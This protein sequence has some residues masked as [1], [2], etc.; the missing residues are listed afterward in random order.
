LCE[1]VRVAQA[2]RKTLTRTSALPKS[3]TDTAFELAGLLDDP[4]EA[5]AVVRQAEDAG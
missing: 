5:G 2:P 4:D 3:D 1:A